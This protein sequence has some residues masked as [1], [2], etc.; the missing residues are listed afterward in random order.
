MISEFKKYKIIIIIILS[1]NILSKLGEAMNII[2]ILTSISLF[3]HILQ[4]EKY[5]LIFFIKKR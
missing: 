4:Q 1:L 3:I 2:F 5:Y